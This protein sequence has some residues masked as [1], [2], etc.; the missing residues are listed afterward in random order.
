MKNINTIALS[1]A[2]IAL[3]TMTG[4]EETKS[5]VVKPGGSTN[6]GNKNNNDN[7]TSGTNKHEQVKFYGKG[8]DALKAIYE[9]NNATDTLSITRTQAQLDAATVIS[10]AITTDKILSA[11]TLW[12]LEGLV[13][14]QN[15]TLTIEPGTVIFAEAGK[16][17]LVVE[18]GAK[19]MADGTASKPITF[20]SA[21][22]LLNPSDADVAQWGGI[23]ILG[24][25][26]INHTDA[27]YE[28]DESKA[29]FAFGGT[30]ADDNSGI[31]RNVYILNSG[32]TVATDLEINGLSLAGV[33]RGTVI[34]NI[35]V[36]NSSDDCIEIWGGTVN[37]TNAM[38]VN[39][40]DDSF[41][42]DYGYVGTA[43]NIVVQQTEATHSGFEISSGGTT[44]MTSPTIKNFIINK[45]AGSDDGGIYIKDDTTAPTFIDGVVSVV[46]SDNDGAIKVRK[47]MST[48]QK[49][50][51]AFK[52]VILNSDVKYYGKGADAIK[53]RFEANDAS[54]L[55][56]SIT[57]TQAQLD[58]ATVI[59]G[60]ITT[61]KILSADTLWKLEG[62]VEVQNATLTIE[63]GTVIFAEAGKN[64]L[65]V[66][67]GAKI[68][69]DGTAS[70][71]ITFTSAKALLNPSDADVAQWG[72]ITILGDAPINHTDAHYEV[73]ESKAEF[74]FGGTN[75]DDNSGILR[76]VYILNSG[77]TV[78]TDLEINGLSLA[79]V[80]RGTVIENIN[81]TNSSDDCIEI[82]GGTVNVTNAML[83]NCQDDSF[84]LDYGYVGTAQNIVVQ[85]TEATH[86]G[87][88]IS[89]GGTTPMTS[90]TIKNFIIN[91]V[92]GSDD[93]GIYIKD[94]TTAPTF[95]DGVVSVVSSDNDGA[96][97]VRK[98]MSSDQK[99]KMKFKNVI[100]KEV[101]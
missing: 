78:A 81:V 88:E 92:A 13:E 68:M 36:T 63:P 95:I 80:G 17:Y 101:Q 57:R 3:I 93:G 55:D 74:A 76:N 73:D 34:E 96:I 67:K 15:A 20:T 8:A 42:L 18:K 65:V 40:Q 56:V 53:S 26:P 30:N 28:V 1:L 38:L 75:A 91:K 50:T 24:D 29:E 23:T 32:K 16:N 70:K 52:N 71:P 33:G 83:V 59:S 64:Y 77:K 61:D 97:R 60:A 58:A 5:P 2:T 19:I 72:G 79:G 10:G 31:L 7:T 84:D 69:A 45:V 62:L 48:D 47:A 99:S 9:A 90:P 85:Q 82:W 27:H 49:N 100:L 4:C 14:V 94:D 39:C 98:A 6:S 22:A 66:E 86:S 37:V 25:A 54:L 35:N 41:D 87:F 89:S 21:K 44:P 11:D 43:Q 51:I 12:K 46:S